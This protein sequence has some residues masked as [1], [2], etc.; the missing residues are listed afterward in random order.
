MKIMDI[1]TKKKKQSDTRVRLSNKY[2]E[3][4][5]PKGKN[6]S[7][8]DSEFVGL[9]IYVGRYFKTF[10]Y[11]YVPKGLKAKDKTRV[12]IGSWPAFNIARARIEAQQ[13]AVKRQEGKDKRT[14][15][16]A[17]KEEPTLGEWIYTYFKTV[18]KEPKYKLRTQKHWKARLHTWVLGNAKDKNIKELISGDPTVRTLKDKKLSQ[19]TQEDIEALFNL[20]TE[21]GSKV[22]A[23]RTLVILKTLFNYAMKK[24]II[25]GEDFENPCNEISLHEEPEDNK[26]FTSEQTDRI[27][28]LT[29]RF[30]NNYPED[31][32]KLLLSHYKDN[33]LKLV[34]CCLVSY[35]VLTG[36]RA[37]TEGSML[38]WE[39]I[40]FE[41]CKV[42]Y[43][44]SKTGVMAYDLDMLTIKLLRAIKN[45]RFGDSPFR[46][47]GDKRDE[48]VFPSQKFPNGSK[49]PYL[50]KVRKTWSRILQ[51]LKISYLPIKQLRHSFGT[52]SLKMHGLKMTSELMG[53]SKFSTTARYAKFVDEDRKI[54][55]NQLAQDRMKRLEELQSN[56]VT[57]IEAKKVH[58]K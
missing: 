27:L 3:K 41:N 20:M 44:T 35:L 48:Y 11:C 15:E 18:L 42:T 12:K 22:S 51:E 45:Y 8:G 7:V 29:L 24:K 54:A 39:Y 2:I 47:R 52:R 36:R 4:L 43:P 38:K 5:E 34:P 58:S 10:Y 17:L 19:V 57:S 53:H 50:E 9:R 46:L 1:F 23:N 25:K 28:S 6:Y 31:N 56:N 16:N 30:N 55:I 37:V 26:F 14:I 32:P 49:L 33:R 40:D 21:R 13:L